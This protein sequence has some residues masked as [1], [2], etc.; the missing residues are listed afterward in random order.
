MR[1][2]GQALFPG[3]AYRC[4]YSEVEYWV[5]LLQEGKMMKTEDL[6][7]KNKGVKSGKSF[8]CFR[9]LFGYT[10]GCRHTG[11]LLVCL[12]FLLLNACSSGTVNEPVKGP[13]AVY[14]PGWSAVHADNGNSDYSPVKGHKNLSLAWERRFPNGQIYLGST[15]DDRGRLY[16]TTSAPGCHLYALNQ[17]TGETLWCSDR[18]NASAISS[19]P[20]IDRDGRLFV[21][22]NTAMFAFDRDGNVIWENP[23]V[24]STMSCQFT[25]TGRL[26][27][28]TH[29]G[30]IYVLDRDTGEPVLPPVELIPGMTYDPDSP[31]QPVT[32]CMRGT[33]ECPSANTIAT[34]REGRF[35]FTFFAPE[36]EFAGLWAMKYNETPSPSITPYWTNNALPGGSGSSPVLSADG[37]R[38]YT[39]DNV[40]SIHAI[41]ADTGETIWSFPIGYASGGSPSVSPEGII[42]PTG[43]GPLMAIADRG[44]T[45]ELLWRNDEIQNNS[46]PTQVAGGIAYAAI[47]KEGSTYENDL[48]VFD[49]HSGTILDRELLPG[50]TI[51]TVGTTIGPDA[52]VYISSIN[53]RLFAFRPEAEMSECGWSEKISDD[54]RNIFFIDAE[55]TYWSADVEIPD[56]GDIAV[57]GAFPHA[58]YMSICVYDEK[59]RTV[60]HL[61]DRDIIPDPGSIN[62]F[63]PGADR[64]DP[65]RMYTLRIVNRRIPEPGRSPNTLYTE[66]SDGTRSAMGLDRVPVTLRI[67][68]PDAGADETGAVGLPEISTENADGESIVK[69]SCIDAADMTLPIDPDVLARMLE[70]RLTSENPPVWEKFYP[71]GLGENIDAAYIYTAIDANLGK[72]AA[73][74]AKAPTFPAT[75]QNEPL[76]GVGQL[77]YWSVCTNRITTA[78]M[79][80][81]RD[82]DIPTDPEGIYTVVISRPEDRPANATKACGIIWLPADETGRT[83]LVYRHILPDPSFAEAIQNIPELGNIGAVMADY[84]PQGTYYA[85]KAEYERLGCNP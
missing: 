85:N 5:N 18:V 44:E 80:S 41:D 22:D 36:A 4:R 27:F 29:I 17:E 28:I 75:R 65:D 67:Y 50:I 79:E 64:T 35:F 47:A 39:N 11:F 74:R 10:A 83:I 72:V 52:T 2:P 31:E 23:I 40:D 9:S 51:F 32:A 8:L 7:Y 3:I 12:A 57:R 14:G 53:G 25:N 76:M 20:L 56:N 54:T 84:Y 68:A 1:N 21:A 69:S 78:V 13:E 30:R 70:S 24:G 59:G 66:N 38:L 61:T 73:F 19:S 6:P 26:I 62:P 49:T 33:R 34:D 55:A 45:A 46:I 81:I 37:T 60:D 15:S 58:R 42:T 77:R 43:G 71:D 63:L 48:I 82:E 16:V